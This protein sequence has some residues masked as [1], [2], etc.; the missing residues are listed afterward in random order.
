MAVASELFE[1]AAR[2]T[3]FNFSTTFYEYLLQ[4]Y[5]LQAILKWITIQLK[6]G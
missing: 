5:Y 3:A 1:L 4:I 6:G 2:G